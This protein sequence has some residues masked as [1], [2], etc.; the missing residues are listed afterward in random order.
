MLLLIY[1]KH[2]S[3]VGKILLYLKRIKLKNYVLK[4]KTVSI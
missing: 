4:S 1:L 3:T 2:F